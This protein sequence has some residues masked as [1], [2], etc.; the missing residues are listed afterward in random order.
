MNAQAATIV[1]PSRMWLG[2]RARPLPQFGGR[3]GKGAINAT[4]LT[5]CTS[6]RRAHA[7]RIAANPRLNAWARCCTVR[8]A[9]FTRLDRTF[10]HPTELPSGLLT[11]RTRTARCR[12]A[13]P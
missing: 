8:V 1:D 2:K 5:K 10:A 3:V 12:A 7:A 6:Q 11:A 4:N 9:T 13:A